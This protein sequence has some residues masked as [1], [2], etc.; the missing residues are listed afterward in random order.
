MKNKK[1]K[2]F[3]LF[4]RGKSAFGSIADF[5]PEDENQKNLSIN[6]MEGTWTYTNDEGTFT[7]KLNEMRYIKLPGHGVGCVYDFSEVTQK[8]LTR[9]A[10]DFW[11]ASLSRAQQKIQQYQNL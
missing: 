10:N 5:N 7:R 6:E 1:K 8:L 9:L 2:Y 11:G 3:V 4:F